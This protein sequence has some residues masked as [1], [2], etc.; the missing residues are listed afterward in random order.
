M[1]TPN[2]CNSCQTDNETNYNC[3][4]I[5]NFQLLIDNIPSSLQNLSYAIKAYQ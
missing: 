4:L 2:N 1:P 3:Y 5:Q